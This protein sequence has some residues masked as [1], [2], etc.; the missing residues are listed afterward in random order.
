MRL[1]LLASAAILTGSLFGADPELVGLAMPDTQVM[2]GVNVE[3][4]KLSPLGQFL[5]AQ[6]PQNSE[7]GLQELTKTTGF[8]PRR[9][10][11]EILVC[12]NGLPANGPTLLLARGAFDVPK[13]LAAAVADGGKS[14][15]YKGVPIVIRAARGSLALPDS[16]LA[17]VGDV[18]DL[19]AAID[20]KTSP[21]AIGSALAV[22]VNQLSTSE[23]AWFVSMVP[24]S[25]LQ[26]PAAANSGGSGPNPMAMYSKVQQ[27]SGGVKFG[28]NMV[29][30]LQAVSE[31][32]QDAAMLATVLKAM[33]IGLSGNSQGDLGVAAALLKSLNVTADGKITTVS[34][35]VPEQQLEQMMASHIEESHH[36]NPPQSKI[37][38]VPQRIRVGSAV[39]KAKLLQHPEPVCPAPALQARIS[40]VMHLNVVIGKDGTVQKVS[41]ASGH[42]LLAGPAMEAVKQ[43]TY[44]PTLLNGQALEVATQV[45]VNFDCQQ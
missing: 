32:D 27:A 9:D 4:V 7:G 16:T 20:R 34:L 19:H 44:A 13:I 43:W 6:I 23:D 29:V 36:A 12:T 22:Q 21:T 37:E 25:Q 11:R 31:T 26:G 35:T 38:P 28:A 18:A 15:T 33:G 24:P 14:E 41:L 45:E 10:L 30:S 1:R 5:L 8:D 17:I 40:G 3:Q 42:P 2:A 39:Q